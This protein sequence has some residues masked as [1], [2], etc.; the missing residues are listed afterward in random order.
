MTFDSLRQQHLS[1]SYDSFQYYLSPE[2]NGLLEIAFQFSL[3][4]N[5]VF[6]PKLAI[7][8]LDSAKISSISSSFIDSLVFHLGMAELPSYWKCACPPHITIKAGHLS[9]D[10]IEWWQRLF[11]SGLGEFYYLNQINFLKPNLLN[12]QLNFQTEADEALDLASAL[13]EDHYQTPYLVP[14]GGGKDSGLTLGL[15]DQNQA[16]YDTLVLE[17]A[18]PAAA[19]L[20]NLSQASSSIVVKR[21][22]CPKLLELNQRGYLNGHTPF[23]AYLAF[24]STLVAHLGGNQQILVANESSANQ[25]NLKFQ[26]TPINHQWSKS[27]EFEQA[28]RNY[29]QEYLGSKPGQAEYISFLR[30][31]NELQIAQKFAQLD[32]H[33][34]RFKSCNVGQKDDVWCHQCPKCIFVFLMLFPFVDEKLLTNQ[35]FSSNLFQDLSLLPTFK[36]LADPSLDKPLE[37][38]G[39]DEEVRLALKM[40][41]NHYIENS[42]PLPAVLSELQSWLADQPINDQLLEEW[43]SDHNLDEKLEKILERP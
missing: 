27:Y 13:K 42:Q 41:I 37:C 32:D 14:V 40:S 2:K 28:F 1:L 21:T 18:S 23:S 31:L 19:R 6:R 20:A 15:L 3:E 11:L 30:P 9:A 22:I 16:S 17:P 4:P 7:S 10:Q 12:F 25:P 34:P 8:G 38:V 5:I 33:L 43:N 36:Q 29:A 24:L 39:T 26:D 35:V